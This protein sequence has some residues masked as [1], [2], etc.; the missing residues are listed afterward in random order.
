MANLSTALTDILPKDFKNAARARGLPKQHTQGRGLTRPVRSQQAKAGPRQNIKTQVGNGGC[1]IELLANIAAVDY[2][3]HIGLIGH[4]GSA[5][6]L[7]LGT[8][9]YTIEVNRQ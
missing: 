1:V 4:E 9:H 6:R 5:G 7:S 3:G 2:H 8:E